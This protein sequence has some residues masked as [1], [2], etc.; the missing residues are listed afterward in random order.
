MSRILSSLLVAAALVASANAAPIPVLSYAMP[1]GAGQASGGTYNYW[2]ATYSGSGAVTTDGAP[3]SGG[4]GKL[5]DGVVATQRWDAVSNVAGTG[6]Y[7]GWATPLTPA[8]TITFDFATG[9]LIDTVVVSLDNSGFGGVFAPSAIVIDGLARAFT[10]PAL[11]SVGDVVFTGLGL[12]GTSH[13][14]QFS[15]GQGPWIFVS[16]IAFAGPTATVPEPGSMALLGLGL[17]GLALAAR[18]RG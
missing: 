4:T 8:P 14:I 5:T 15:G 12:T 1:N 16:E 13:T 18:R 6:E 17:F 7:V 11:G 10:A 2:D 9:A 3:L